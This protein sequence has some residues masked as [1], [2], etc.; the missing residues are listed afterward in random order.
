MRY[1]E[2]SIEEHL[3]IQIYQLNCF[4]QRTIARL[5]ERRIST[6]S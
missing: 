2:L 1:H 4:S 3:M 5:L 6:V